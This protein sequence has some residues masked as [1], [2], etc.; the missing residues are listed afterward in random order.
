VG[1]LDSSTDNAA[2]DVQQAMDMGLSAFAM[3]I[4]EPSDLAVQSTVKQLFDA[5]GQTNDKF[6]LFFSFDLAGGDTDFQNHI[7]LFAQFCDNPA[8]LTAGPSA[9]PMVSS[10]GGYDQYDDWVNLKNSHQVSLMLNLDSDFGGQGD[11]SEYYTNPSDYLAK[12]TDISDG[13]FSWEAAWPPA[14]DTPTNI[15]SAGDL[16]VEEFAHSAQK[17]YMMGKI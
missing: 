15:T 16:N 5:A 11:T 4:G 13:F 2:L 12:F 9:F 7:D 10:F 8:Y 3:N 1:R 17:D 14:S 6:K